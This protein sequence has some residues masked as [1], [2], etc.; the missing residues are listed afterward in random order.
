M[1]V[2]T[3]R[4]LSIAA[5]CALIVLL[6]ALAATPALAE[7]PWGFTKLP[8]AQN[9]AM[10]TAP[11][12]WAGCA[13]SPGNVWIGGG[14]NTVMRYNGNSWAMENGNIP[15][16]FFIAGL[17]A[18]DANHIWG[19]S[20]QL[21]IYFHNGTPGANWVEQKAPA[22]TDNFSGA[23]AL[24]ASNVWAVGD[25]S[26]I[27]KLDGGA[28]VDDHSGAPAGITLKSVSG[29]D[30]DHVWAAGYDGADGKI[31]FRGTDATKWDDVETFAGQP[32][33]CVKAIAPN[34]VWAGG[35][36]GYLTHYDGTN[37]TAVTPSPMADRLSSISAINAN[38]IWITGGDQYA[39]HYDG[40]TWTRFN[41]DPAGGRF[42]VAVATGP[43]SVWFAGQSGLVFQGGVTRISSVTPSWA[44]QGETMNVNI[45]GIA[46]NFQN[47]VSAAQFSG[48]G[49]TVNS[50]TVTDATHATARITI[51]PN[52]KPGLRN[53]NVVTG[54]EV[55][56][57]LAS[58]F[59]VRAVHTITLNAG[60]HGRIIPVL[61]GPGGG[62]GRAPAATSTVK[63]MDGDNLALAI[64]PDKDY[65]TTD[66]VIDGGVH[67]GTVKDYTFRNVKANHTISAAFSDKYSTWY[68]AEGSSAWGFGAAISIQ[69]P[70]DEDLNANVTYMLAD[71]TTKE[72]AVG[73]PKMSQAVVSPVETVGEADFST[74]V[75]CVQGETIAVDR[76]MAWHSGEGQ[77]AGAHNSIGVTAPSTTWY[78]PEGSSNWG[79]E[80]WLLIQNPGDVE[81]SCDVTYMIEGVGPKT[82][83]HVVPAHS[84]ATY[85]LVD[86][87]GNA[88]A[89][90]KVDSNVGVIP[91]R[92]M[93]T[94]WPAAG[95]GDAGRREGHESI[96]ALEP[97]KDFYL[98]EG[99]TAW[100]FTTYVLIQNPNA[101]PANVTLTYMTN[102]GPVADE[103]FTMPANSRKTV[104][105]ND[106]HPNKDLS[107]RVSANKPIVAERSMFW[108]LPGV[109]GQATHDSI[110][111][112][113]AHMTWF[114]PDGGITPD[115]GGS[116]T[117]TLV[118][119]PNAVDVEV[120]VS[121]LNMGG[122]ENVV[123]TD[124]V[125]AN[126]RKTYNMADRYPAG[127]SAWASIL[128]ES[129]TEGEKIIVERSMYNNGRWGGTDTIGGWD[130]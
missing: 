128:V 91:E 57:Q 81:A 82:V 28:W 113:A 130:D 24:D 47:G 61:P 119:N 52:A 4:T 34:D 23:Y 39:A 80:T 29:C 17:A 68:L 43:D 104:R 49:I 126:S 69:N 97:A 18:S 7:L 77:T 112:S 120:Q 30:A 125:P 101:T 122:Q 62:A 90:I 94:Y 96:G 73:L 100:G 121:Y 16:D 75:E 72:L 10:P 78:L 123:F 37:W 40:T 129:R 87:I 66:V 79:F 76:T 93:Y 50:T 6:L 48:G 21:S 103:P 19:V 71:G 55:P 60:A 108:S 110:G 99:T 53:V 12:L 56:I 111:T 31:L 27:W 32:M 74:K 115:D 83:N 88:D 13:L 44:G 63:V 84:R 26:N 15:V 58:G 124:T 42:R 36:N 5:A 51:A 109:A 127:A 22:G 65:H 117:F 98:A 14:T 20:D 105:V 89:S 64:T 3:R 114:L 8:D 33:R 85:N 59:R 9:P 116:E 45:V 46:T 41:V 95:A 2:L 11:P 67:L 38:D 1:T 92:A 86:E 107:T 54:A 70:N 25:A 102:E 35:N 106:A 118:Q